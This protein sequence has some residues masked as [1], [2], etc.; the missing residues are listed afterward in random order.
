M[1]PHEAVEKALAMIPGAFC[2][3]CED[4]VLDEFGNRYT[5]TNETAPCYLERTPSTFGC[6]LGR[7][8]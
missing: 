6:V 2:K 4:W 8:A 3:E 1:T 5:F 7:R